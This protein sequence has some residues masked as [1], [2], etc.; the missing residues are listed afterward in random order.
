[1]FGRF[2]VL[3][4]P[5]ESAPLATIDDGLAA[6][7]PPTEFAAP[8]VVVD[9]GLAVTL[10]L[11]AP[12]LTLFAVGDE[13]AT[14][15]AMPPGAL[16]PFP[17]L[18]FTVVVM[19]AFL[20]LFILLLAK[21]FPKMLAKLLAKLLPI[22]LLDDFKGFW[23]FISFAPAA[24][25]VNDTKMKATINRTSAVFTFLSVIPILP[26][27]KNFIRHPFL[28]SINVF[29]VYQLHYLLIKKAFFY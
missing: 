18:L 4:P 19:S 1:V 8:A 25:T 24:A 2:A 29:G 21:L 16:P 27:Q 13:V 20:P 7:L 5:V 3:L 26:L 12:E 15:E 28:L 9:D 22:L 23:I 6:L 11:F 17:P 14:I 10:P